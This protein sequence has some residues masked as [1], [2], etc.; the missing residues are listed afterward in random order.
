MSLRQTTYRER[1]VLDSLHLLSDGRYRVGASELWIRRHPEGDW[2]IYADSLEG[3][4]RIP[5]KWVFRT[6]REARARA[7]E[8]AKELGHA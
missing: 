4:M 2:G 3:P 1:R 5:G 8:L 6:L 7:F